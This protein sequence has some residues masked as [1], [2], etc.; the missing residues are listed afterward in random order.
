VPDDRLL[1]RRAGHSE[2]FAQLSDV[3]WRVWTTYL[4]TADD[5]G[6]MRMSALTVQEACDALETRP[7]SVIDDALRTL[8][9]VKLLRTFEHQRRLYL[10]QHDWQDWQKI[11]YPRRTIDPQPPTKYGSRNMQWL[12]TSW[13][14]GQK[15]PLP[16]WKAPESFTCEVVTA[17][18]E[19]LGNLSKPFA[20]DL[21]VPLAVSRMPLAPVCAPDEDATPDA[22]KAIRTRTRHPEGSA[23]KTPS[24]VREFLTWFQAEYK[25]RRHGATYFVKWEQH[26]K[27]VKDLL[28]VFPQERLRKH[29]YLL[30]TTDED[31]TTGTDRGIG[32]LSTKINWLEER[33]CAWE[34]KR[35]AR[36][37]V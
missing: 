10:F 25:A 32:I 9:G 13:P 3:E 33:L 15:K 12:L 27:L 29:A 22:Q 28:R 20:K 31:W 11:T 17:F 14:G 30:L 6:V 4:Y 35:K 23:E 2:K 1:S 36:E 5:F 16:S 19:D 24:G 34:A 26:G 7:A 8:V 18:P 21:S 37:A